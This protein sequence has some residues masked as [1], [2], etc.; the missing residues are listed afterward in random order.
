MGFQGRL[1]DASR[2]SEVGFKESFLSASMVFQGR[3]KDA[4]MES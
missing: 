1:K 4:S 2:E 3:L